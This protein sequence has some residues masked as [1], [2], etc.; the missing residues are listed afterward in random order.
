[1][2]VAIEA[3]ADD[4]Q[5]EDDGSLTVNTTPDSFSDVLENIKKAGLQPES[6]ELTMLASV[7]V[8]LNFED[9]QQFMKMVDMLE[10]LDDVQEVYSNAEISEEIANQLG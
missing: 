8:P 1:M 4:V 6:A 9:A 10:D 7:N 5:Q 2:E 3:G